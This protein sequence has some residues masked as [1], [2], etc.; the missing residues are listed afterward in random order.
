MNTSTGEGN[1]G[2]MEMAVVFE[3][4]CA[5]Q[6]CEGFLSSNAAVVVVVVVVVVEA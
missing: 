3:G 2:L 6:A 5:L 1:E 4:M